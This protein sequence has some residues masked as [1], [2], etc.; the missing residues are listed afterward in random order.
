MFILNHSRPAMLLGIIAG[1]VVLNIAV[2]S[3]GLLGVAIGGDSTLE[4]AAGVTL[5][6]VSLLIVLYGSYTLLFNPPVIHTA[7]ALETR[8]DYIT[9]LNRYRNV[10]VLSEDAALA[11]DQLERIDKKKK[12]LLQVLDG[13]FER[14]ELSFRKFNTVIQEVEKLLYLNIR[15]ILSKLS[16]FDAAEF[17]QFT[18]KKNTGRFSNALLQKKNTLYNEYFSYVKNCLAANEEI[19]LKLDQLLL[20]LSRL[21]ST[22]AAAALEMPCMQELTALIGQTKLYQQ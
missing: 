12:I 4:T 8:E 21:G 13:R 5:L 22:D 3:P 19:L 15:S 16:V 6:I 1:I 10:R 2:L 7:V 18:G 20:E 9:A 11:L 17:A 14:T